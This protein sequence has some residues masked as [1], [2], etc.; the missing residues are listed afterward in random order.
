MGPGK[1]RA[2][3]CECGGHA[4]APITRGLVTL[5]SP[6]DFAILD[7]QRW[8]AGSSPPKFYAMGAIHR[9]MV[10]LHRVITNAAKGQ[11]VDHINRNKLDNRRENLRFVT[12]SQNSINRNHSSE[13]R[14]V[15]K[16]FNK[17]RASIGV[18]RSNIKLG[19]FDTP[20]AAAA[21]Y[22]EAAK[23]LHGEFAVLNDV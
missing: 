14:G 7:N 19:A 4:W 17:W 22:N 13:F 9:Q 18:N 20:E 6:Q 10:L 23:R 5:V 16:T 15:F 11:F 8:C 1:G 3:L 21:A 12:R 2:H